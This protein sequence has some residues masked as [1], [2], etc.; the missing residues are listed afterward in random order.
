MLRTGSAQLASCAWRPPAGAPRMGDHGSARPPAVLLR[1]AVW[2]RFGPCRAARWIQGPGADQLLRPFPTPACSVSVL[3]ASLASRI[4]VHYL[5][6][7]FCAPPSH[8][9]L[10][11]RAASLGFAFYFRLLPFLYFFTFLVRRTLL[12]PLARLAFAAA[13]AQYAQVSTAIC[14]IVLSGRA[15]CSC[16]V[17]RNVRVGWSGGGNRE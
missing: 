10:S 13:L 5:L 1:L 9:P 12:S 16:A 17:A 11:H 3:P 15:I 6:R 4:P 2:G 7:L 8:H 14:Q